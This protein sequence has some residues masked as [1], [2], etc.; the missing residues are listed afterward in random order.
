MLNE[1]F[2]A[3]NTLDI[4][5]ELEGKSVDDKQVV[6]YISQVHVLTKDNG[7]INLIHEQVGDDEN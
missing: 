6:I 4:E 3:A 7:I 1:V 2:L 5:Y